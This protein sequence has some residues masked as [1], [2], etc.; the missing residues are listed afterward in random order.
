MAADYCDG[1][2]CCCKDDL[3][4][5]EFNSTARYSQPRWADHRNAKYY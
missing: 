4:L 2:T 1:K 3:S 5:M